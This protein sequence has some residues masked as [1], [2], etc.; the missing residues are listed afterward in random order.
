MSLALADW[1]EVLDREYLA[2]FVPR[3]GASVKI[4]ASPVGTQ[5]AVLDAVAAIARQ[6]NYTVARIDAGETRVQFIEQVFF[7]VSRQTDW[8]GLAERW[9]RAQFAAN[10][11]DLPPEQRLDDLDGIAARMEMSA[12]EVMGEVRRWIV[13]GLQ[14]DYRLTREL[15]TAMAMLCLAVVNPVNVSPTDAEVLLQWLHGAKYSLSTLKKLQIFT[16]IGRHN[17]RQLLTSL[18]RWLQ[19]NG[20]DGLVILLDAGEVW[21]QTPSDPERPRV[22]YTRN[23]TLDLFEVLRQFIDE[24]DDLEHFLLLVAVPPEF[25]IDPKKGVSQYTALQMRVA[26]EVRDRERANPLGAA[27]RLE[28]TVEVGA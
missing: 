11:V 22:R 18:A 10:G 7:A 19:I 28:V 26:D 13:N 9:L 4:A 6:R 17:A 25:W 1:A 23:A 20:Q 2:E 27:V 12:R 15:R 21:S 8:V 3:G 24:T 5:S 16:R 14:K